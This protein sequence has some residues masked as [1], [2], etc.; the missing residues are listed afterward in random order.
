MPAYDRNSE[1]ERRMQELLTNRGLVASALRNRAAFERLIAKYR[2]PAVGYLSW[3][4]ARHKIVGDDAVAETARLIWAELGRELP[5][6]LAE[7]WHD[8]AA[9]FRDLLL[10]GVHEAYYRWSRPVTRALIVPQADDDRAWTGCLRRDLPEKA[11][12]RL[13]SYQ[14]QHQARGNLYYAI[15]RL[16]EKHPDESLEALRGRLES[17]PGGRQLDPA[18][19]RQALGRARDKFGGYLFDEVAACIATGDAPTPEQMVKAFQEFDLM[20]DYVLPSKHCRWLL[21]LDDGE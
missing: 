20:R 17:L 21:G 18:A 3:L 12:Q 2:D 5:A 7:S 9:S 15:F 1:W 14:R 10:E 8:G 6:K 13:R 16:W 19:F 11:R 4:L